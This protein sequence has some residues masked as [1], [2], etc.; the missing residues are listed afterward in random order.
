MIVIFIFFAN[1]CKYSVLFFDC[2]LTVINYVLESPSSSEE[3]NS[4]LAPEIIEIIINCLDCR[5]SK[6]DR[7][8]EVTFVLIIN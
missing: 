8:S 5:L 4:P 2:F 7:F 3:R 1:T 6:V